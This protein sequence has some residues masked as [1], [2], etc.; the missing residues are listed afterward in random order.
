MNCRMSLEVPRGSASS[1]V[2]AETVGRASFVDSGKSKRCIRLER[3]CAA[4][5]PDLASL[6]Y[7]NARDLVE[8]PARSDERSRS[9]EV[10][11]TRID[12]RRSIAVVIVVGDRSVSNIRR[13][14]ERERDTRPSPRDSGVCPS[15]I[16]GRQLSAKF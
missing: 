12:A 15:P 1:R 7:R 5:P 6:K 10:R 3:G 2:K 4:I 13:R 8:D 16:G 11:Q 14:R 9:M